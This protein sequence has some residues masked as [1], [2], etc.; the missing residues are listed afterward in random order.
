MSGP[1]PNRVSVL[2]PPGRGAV[3]VIAAS[4]PKALA[5]IDAAFQAANGRRLAQQPIDRIV[6]GHWTIGEHREEVVVLR[7]EG[8]VVEVHCHGGAA[9]IA[10]IVDALQSNGCEQL[11]WIDWLKAQGQDSITLE[12]NV[13]LAKA[14]TRRTA[15]ILLDQRDGALGRTLSEVRDSLERG[16][17]TDA[18]KKLSD[19]LQRA[20]LGLHITEPWQIAIAGPPNVGKSSLINALVGYQ[21][22]IVFDQ[23]GTTRDVLTAETAIDGWPVRLADAAGIRSTDDPLESAGVALA[24]EQLRRADLILWIV[25]AR[26]LNDS[27]DVAV[28]AH[29]EL[30]RAAGEFHSRFE[31]LIVVNKIDLVPAGSA[32]R[33]GNQAIAVSALTRAGLDELITAISNRL[34]PKPSTLGEAVPFTPRQVVQLQQTHAA[35]TARDLSAAIASLAAL[36]DGEAAL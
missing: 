36:L 8:D 7:G 35:L 24:R 10:R 14:N 27:E 23:P 19:L 6:F 3:A 1:A 17:L 31:S 9:A 30:A 15:A 13:A 20:M 12:A 33:M 25:D 26:T 32:A 11:S 28:V 18:E 22:A 16:D 4:G 2:T 5:A 21:R 34:V 29:R